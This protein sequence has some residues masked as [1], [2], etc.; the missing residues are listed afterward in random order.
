VPSVPI[1]LRM[2]LAAQ[3]A[4]PVLPTVICGLAKPLTRLGLQV[5][6]MGQTCPA[7]PDGNA[8]DA[9]T[10]RPL[11][12]AAVTHRIAA[13][14]TEDVDLARRHAAPDRTRQ[15]LCADI[16]GFRPHTASA[17][18]EPAADEFAVATAAPRQGPLPDADR[19]PLSKPREVGHSAARIRDDELAPPGLPGPSHLRTVRPGELGVILA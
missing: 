16:R 17:P 7:E 5:E 8:E 11:Q 18:G 13:R 14:R 4:T 9:R 19:E 10:L 3:P 6:E 1:P 15:P 2:L 12:A